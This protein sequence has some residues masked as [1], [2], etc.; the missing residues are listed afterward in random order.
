M[1][2]TLRALLVEDSAS[3]AEL[4]VRALRNAGFRPVVERV[5][6][7]ADFQRRL[8]D[9]WD[10]ILSDYSLPQFSGLAALD[11]LQ[12]S[13]LDLPFIIISGTIG[14]ETAVEAM[15]R[16]ASDYLLK[17]RLARLEPAV[18][19]ALA[20]AALRREHRRA[21]EALAESE[22]RF[23][24]LAENIQE[25][26]WITNA[27]RNQMLYVSPAF[28]RLWGLPCTDLYER[29]RLWF[30]V[31]HEDDR[32]RVAEATA[33]QAELGYDIEFRILH[34]DGT[35]RWIH[36]KAFPVRGPDG[37]IYRMVGVAEDVTERR[38]LEERILR[39]QRM[40]VIAAM[41][42]GITH[43][44]N[45]ILGS[46]LMAAGL[47]KARLA[48]EG[49]RELLAT[50][51]MGAQRGARMLSQLL[52]FSRGVEGTKST[53]GLGAVLEELSGL[54][55]ATIPRYIEVNV[56]AAPDL[57][58][59]VADATQL[60]QVLMNLCVNARDAMAGGGVLQ[61]EAKNAL[62][63]EADVAPYPGARP[64]WHVVLRVSDSG[65]GIPPDIIG[66]IFDP[67]FT[68][69]EVGKG[70]GLGL[71]S[72][73]GIV[74]NHGGFVT[75]ESEVGRGSTF[76]V[77]LPAT[78][79][80][81][82]SRA[83][84]SG[85]PFARGCGERVLVVDDDADI[86]KVTVQLLEANGYRAIPTVC[87][88]DGLRVFLEQADTIK[89]VITNMHMPGMGGL[90]LIRA[91]RVLENLHVGFL[92]VSGEDQ[93]GLQDEFE[94]LGVSEF[95]PKPASP[96]QLLRAVAKAAQTAQMPRRREL[97]S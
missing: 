23:R 27:R 66:R 47:V 31:V 79:E 34:A 7:A 40:E 82:V 4:L 89:V 17:D 12:A 24:Q 92:V 19:R 16:G 10:L 94:R 90:A 97:G 11:L 88:E 73:L 50:V 28:E 46:M 78:A 15:R 26:F 21:H 84:S 77:H 81:P 38:R 54:M 61:I 55:R 42:S 53:I 14:E 9:G 74:R 52:T 45:N 64:G 33:R 39:A 48:E 65:S 85:A 80:T 91:L 56:T 60:H 58:Y 43:D 59:V 69:K 25:V 95:L 57:M 29:P 62:L 3:D 44:L 5:D 93:S 30:D 75:V 96:S 32:A 36:D 41:T 1:L 86:L 8:H 67:F 49:D 20:Q 51:E 83:S 22:Q 63:S 2:Q 70:T 18:S 35:V 76:R 68:T 37:L 13:G 6:N 71:A 72:V 87:A